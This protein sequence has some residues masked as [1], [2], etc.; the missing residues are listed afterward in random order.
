MG[1]IHT[2][3]EQ[4]SVGTPGAITQHRNVPTE[5]KGQLTDRHYPQNVPMAQ[6]QKKPC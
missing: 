2:S 6:R 3:S 5:Q 1:S 4:R